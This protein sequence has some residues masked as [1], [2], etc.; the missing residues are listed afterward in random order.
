MTFSVYA[1]DM[2]MIGLVE[3]VLS[4]LWIR[5]FREPGEFSMQVPFSDAMNE[6]LRVGNLLM[7]S[8]SPEAMEITFK[9]L[10]KDANDMDTI[11]VR[12]KTLMQWFDRRV[13]VKK[14][15]TD[16][17]S[18]LQILQRMI[19]ENVT[20]PTAG[21]RKIASMQLLEREDE[22]PE[23]MDYESGDYAGLLDAVTD[24]LSSSQLGC[25]ITTDPAAGVHSIDFVSPVDKT[26]S[27]ACPCIF[28]VDFGSL[29]EQTYTHSTEQY[30]NMAY[31]EGSGGLLAEVGSDKADAE[32]REV[33][34]SATDI[35]AKSTSAAD[36]QKALKK[37]QQR[38]REELAASY[39]V[40]Q[41]FD[42]DAETH[43]AS[44]VYGVDYDLGDRVTCQYR[45]WGIR[46]DTVIS[47][48][49]ETYEDGVRRVSV[50]FGE[51]TPV[52]SKAMK[53]LT[54]R[55]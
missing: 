4:V 7:Q 12:G 8:G 19:R 37:L 35:A 29:G 41:T 17:L 40:E 25:R 55:S 10:Q 28:S 48:I 52:I 31:V 23:A 45:R 33:Y 11:N 24:L 6:M 9:S 53:A 47:E 42:G 30:K 34:V 51:G 26:A 14:I 46:V 32:R 54:K 5:R 13:I 39:P 36:K 3:S 43:T 49:Q 27:S 16:T 22:S 50:F 18:A 38:G 20:E 2:T 21:S 1:P 15:D 44:L